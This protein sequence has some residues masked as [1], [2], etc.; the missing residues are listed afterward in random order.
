M[1]NYAIY[2]KQTDMNRLKFI[3]VLI[4]ALGFFTGCSMLGGGGKDVSSTTGWKYNSPENGGFEVIQYAGQ[5][6][7]PG[8]VFVEGGTFTMGRTEQD[9]MY[10]WN[11]VPR[12]VTV[13]SFYMDETE[14]SNIDYREYLYWLR[15]VYV[16]YPQVYSNAL[17]DTLVWRSALAMNEPYVETYFRHPAY[18]TYPIVGVSWTKASDYCLWRTNRVN[19]QILIDKGILQVNP[20][21]QDEEN[22]DTESYLA[23]KYEGLV[24]KNLPS[25]NPNEEERRVRFEDGYLLPKYRLPTE[26]EWEYAALGYI[27]NSYDERI[28]DRRQY[29]WDGHNVRNANPNDR[30]KIMANFKR[31]RGDMMGVAGALN[32]NAEITADVN[33][34]WPNDFGLY[35]MAGNVNE[36]VM[37]VYRPLSFDDVEDFRPFRG[38][39]FKTK[40]RNPDGTLVNPDSL[41][42]LKYREITEAEA[43]GRNN[44]SK[45]DY[46]NYKDGD[47]MSSLEFGDGEDAKGSDRMYFQGDANNVNEGMSSLVTDKTRVYKGGSWRDR[48]F[49]LNPGTR[50]YL[51]QDASTNDIGFRCAMNRVGSPKGN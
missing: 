45:A 14:I 10:D 11:N 12:R 18:N 43:L 6:T 1:T 3:P 44:Y 9:V 22:F 37:D 4:I 31:G 35:C 30:G 32:D 29:P 39:V 13:S 27:G 20:D 34:Y 7:G 2:K 17:P 38:N 19:E 49:W 51:D 16:S 5:E 46:R 28:T 50:R 26:A 25:L 41:G 8:L 24:D 48:A 21:Q 15:R 42:R 40:V 33:A 36:W 47:L 23:G